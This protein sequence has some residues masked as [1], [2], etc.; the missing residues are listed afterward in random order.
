MKWS[1]SRSTTIALLLSPFGILLISI[2]RLLI[3]SNYNTTTASTV[4]S[5]GGYVNTLIGTLIP[6][7][8]LAMPYFCIGL[9]MFDRAA[10]AI[11]ALAAAVLTSP[12]A[13]SASD[14]I[15]DFKKKQH[16]FLSSGHLHSFIILGGLFLAVFLIEILGFNIQASIRTATLLAGLALLPCALLLYP[17]PIQSDFYA[18]QL[19]QPWIP[20]VV[21]TQTS[22]KSLVGYVLS[23][24]NDWFVILQAD[25]RDVDYIP[26]G[27]VARQKACELEPTSTKRPIIDLFN[28]PALL[29]ICP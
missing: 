26:S 18:Q 10:L 20:A 6:I 5:S 12:A 1:L 2:T 8:P 4:A 11:L 23:D 9:L 7:V 22:G 27:Q 19:R 24:S 28:A 17:L 3:I 29:P 25:N 21:I 13:L 14:I 16:A 15:D